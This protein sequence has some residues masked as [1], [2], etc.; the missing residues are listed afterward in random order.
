MLIVIFVTVP[1]IVYDQLR[2]ADQDQKALLLDGARQQGRMMAEILRPRLG[3][4]TPRLA[5]ELAAALGALGDVA[6]RA[7]LLFRPANAAAPDN[8]FYVA[9]F[10]AVA[11][12]YL[13]RERMDLLE[14]G[15]LAKVR[16][17][18]ATADPIAERYV[19]PSGEEE[20]LTA[21]TP[22]D[23]AAGC[24]VVITSHANAGLLASSIGRPYWK[25]PEIQV[26]TAIYL[27]M[28]L[29]AI[30][31]YLDA[32]NSLRRF[33]AIARAI[34]SG[35][36]GAASF[37]G[38]N[39][40]PELAGIATE[41]DRLVD[42]LRDSA[43]Q[44]RHAAEENAHAF[45]TPI[46]VIAQSLEPLKRISAADDGPRR[47]LDRI[48]QS[49]ERL[50]AMVSAARRMEEMTASLVDPT[51]RRIELLEPMKRIV[52]AYGAQRQANDPDIVL[53]ASANPVVNAADDVLETVIENLLDNA[54]SFSPPGGEVTLSLDADAAGAIITVEDQGPGVPDDKLDRI[55]DRYYTDR[56]PAD[57]AP[58]GIENAHFGIGLWIVRR[59]VEAIGGG[60]AAESRP[61]GGLRVRLRLPAA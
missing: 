28:A 22:I 49:V 15:I 34:R 38:F 43:D 4:V 36:R 46:A 31:L 47:A 54:I 10:P 17:T 1:V 32:W 23:T 26:A 21:L 19:N 60:I 35:R 59:N 53:Q 5:S 2:S 37:A 11:T 40:V 44:M 56:D 27:L 45:K 16:A 30:L 9:S 12:E 58:G 50:D 52:Q 18:C 48:E 3:R 24:W 42:R 25:T 61:G 14:R 33:R 39:R 13:E 7:R 6:I 55:F 41:F 29:F 57:A 20:I 51:L 8:F